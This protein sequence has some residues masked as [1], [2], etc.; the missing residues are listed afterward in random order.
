MLVTIDTYRVNSPLNATFFTYLGMVQVLSPI[1][2]EHSSCFELLL[3][4]R[5]MIPFQNSFQNFITNNYY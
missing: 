2:F 1:V 5:I 4:L 3:W